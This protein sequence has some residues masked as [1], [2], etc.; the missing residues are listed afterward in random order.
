MFFIQ[1]LLEFVL[2]LGFGRLHSG[3]SVK[4][5][6]QTQWFSISS[7]VDK[8]ENENNIPMG[9]CKTKLSYKLAKNKIYILLTPLIVY[10]PRKYTSLLQLKGIISCIN[11]SK[12]NMINNF[13][14]SI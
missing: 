14:L 10:A 7:K 3:K 8:R 12:D 13:P 2:N 6:M 11:Y 4:R 9:Y 1:L 5:H